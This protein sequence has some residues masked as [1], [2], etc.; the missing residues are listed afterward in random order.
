MAAFIKEKVLEMKKEDKIGD[1][2]EMFA[3]KAM[4]KGDSFRCR[5]RR[6]KRSQIED[7]D[8]SEVEDV[9]ME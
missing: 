5:G 4:Y 8:E 2:V 6:R 1:V 9:N 3:R 7:R